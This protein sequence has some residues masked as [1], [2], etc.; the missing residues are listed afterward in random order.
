MGELRRSWRLS[1]PLFLPDAL[2]GLWLRSKGA[3]VSDFALTTDI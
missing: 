1:N 2:D 3:N